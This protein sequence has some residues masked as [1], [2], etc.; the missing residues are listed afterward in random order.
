MTQP[1][2]WKA[3]SGCLDDTIAVRYPFLLS[4]NLIRQNGGI[5]ALSYP[6]QRHQNGDVHAAHAADAVLVAAVAGAA[7]ASADAPAAVRAHVVSYQRRRLLLDVR[8]VGELHM[9]C[10]MML[11]AAVTQ[12]MGTSKL[13]TSPLSSFRA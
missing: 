2:L 3:E 5:Y 1:I 7:A 4:R 9:S 13:C 10:R 11:M 12:L 8:L 6:E